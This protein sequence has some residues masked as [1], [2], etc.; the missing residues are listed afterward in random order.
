M[1]PY[2]KNNIENTLLRPTT[3][4][5]PALSNPVP[6]PLPVSAAR[7]GHRLGYAAPSEHHGG[8]WGLIQVASSAS[9]SCGQ[10]G[11]NPARQ[12]PP[13]STVTT[14]GESWALLPDSVEIFS[15][16]LLWLTFRL[17]V[18]WMRTLSIPTGAVS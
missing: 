16:Y 13:A 8:L 9:V 14:E 11:N 15:P 2:H 4:S 5:S 3:D 12:P 6:L 7:Q 17:D 18:V 1:P 10:N